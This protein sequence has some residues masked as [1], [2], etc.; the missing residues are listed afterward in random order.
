MKPQNLIIISL[1]FRHKKNLCKLFTY[2]DICGVSEPRKR[3][4]TV[5]LLFRISVVADLIV[6]LDISVGAGSLGQQPE[7]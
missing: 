6:G 5:I 2:R 4:S 7:R 3:L 1:R